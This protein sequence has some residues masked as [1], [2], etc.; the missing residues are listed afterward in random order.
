MTNKPAASKD[1]IYI[2]VDDDITTII[3]K[4]EAS[5]HK[6]VALVLPKRSSV[7]Q[8]I[9]NTRLL[10]RSADS[11]DK[12]VVLITSE[13]SLLPLAGAAGLHVAKNL[14]SKPEI[15]D[16]PLD[17]PAA[18]A[19][20]DPDVDPSS[21]KLDYHRSIGE[22][23]ASHSVDEPESIDL[24]EGEGDEDTAEPKAKTAAPPPKDKKLKVPNFERFRLILILGILGVVGFIIFIILAIFVLPKAVITIKT[25]SEPVSTNFTLTTSDSQKT[26]DKEKRIIPS[27]LKTQDQSSSQQA[28]ATGQQNNG[29]KATGSV[30]MSAGACSATVPSDVP[31]GS[32]ITTSGLTFIAQSGTSFAPV[33]SAGKCTYQSTGSTKVTAQT[34]GAKY[35][36]AS[37]TFSV[38]G[39]PD[40]SASSSAAMTGGTDNNITV[41]SQSDVDGAQQKAA[42]ASSADDFKRNLIK[43]LNDSGFYV[44]DSTFKADS[45][46]VSASPDVGQQANTTTVTVKIS[47]SVLMVPKSDLTD[48]IKD[49]LAKQVDKNKQKL[50]NDDVLKTAAVIVQ[51][52]SSPTVASLQVN[53]DTTAVPII[54]VNTVKKQAG[55]QKSGDI[56]KSLESLPGVKEV[57]IKMSPFWVSKAP[58]DSGKVRVILS[59]QSS[60]KP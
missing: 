47:Y 23:A 50:S 33:V 40:V 2:D 19:F 51:S 58:K 43:Q 45:Q 52:Q 10:K 21:A 53:E 7:L 25:E 16:S 24:D 13:P 54:D 38:S 56:K 8:S 22:L 55:G 4:V 57:T 32:G 26:L 60:D 39:R 17:K 46:S 34:A 27:V 29:T 59:Q 30:T 11:A 49:Q 44:L 18:P 5:P 31:A 48:I 41:V 6:V 3:D 15:P 14:Q 28:Q 37:S 12:N 20:D 35:N 42:T 1:T 36:V 9:V